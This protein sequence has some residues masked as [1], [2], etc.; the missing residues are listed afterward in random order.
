MAQPPRGQEMPRYSSYCPDCQAVVQSTR[1]TKI[2][3]LKIGP[4]KSPTGLPW[5]QR[6][7]VTLHVAGA[8]Q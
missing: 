8:G 6:S 7:R 2:P 4:T 3:W 1:K 5:L